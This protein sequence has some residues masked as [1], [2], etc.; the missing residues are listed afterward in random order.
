[1]VCESRRTSFSVTVGLVEEEDDDDGD[2]DT[3]DEDDDDDNNNDE[4]AGRCRPA[5]MVRE[6]RLLVVL[7]GCRDGGATIIIIIIHQLA[8]DFNAESIFGCSFSNCD[9]LSIV[10]VEEE[11][12]DLEI[13][14]FARLVSTTEASN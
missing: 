10:A 8:K 2:G 6:R 3:N 14:F 12:E 11:E 4:D 5:G 9:G 7:G 1:M 13:A